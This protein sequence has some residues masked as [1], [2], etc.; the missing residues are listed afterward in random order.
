M[1]SRELLGNTAP[2]ILAAGAKLSDPVFRPFSRGNK[3]EV[4]NRLGF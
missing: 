1:E 2:V 3:I 4:V